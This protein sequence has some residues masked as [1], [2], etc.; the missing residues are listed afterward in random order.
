MRSSARPGRPPRSSREQI[1]S[2]ALRVFVKQG[3][4]QTTL[5]DISRAVGVSRRTILRYFG[6]KNDIVWGTFDEQLD[7]L[8]DMLAV[9]S[10]HR[11]LLEIIREAV[12][13]FNDYGASAQSEL[14][15]RMTLITTVPALQGHAMLRYAQWCEVIAAFVAS[16]LGMDAEDK[17]CQVVASAVLGVAMATYRHWIAHPDED[18][19]ASL[20]HSLALL[21]AG[22]E[23]R[24][25]HELDQSFEAHRRPASE[26]E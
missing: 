9:A 5:D 4:E 21:G 3:F 17:V 13:A 6:S 26:L 25:L 16:R 10:T 22:F 11:P 18:L 8:R 1:A 19:L 7:R 24:A 15:D 12:V 23:E 20:D 14:R 2:I